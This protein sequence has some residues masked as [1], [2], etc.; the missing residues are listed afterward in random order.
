MR[1]TSEKEGGGGITNDGS[2]Q[3]YGWEEESTNPQ[4]QACT[5]NLIAQDELSSEVSH[6]NIMGLTFSNSVGPVC[7]AFTATKDSQ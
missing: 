1:E 3:C 7:K 4:E 6:R 2:H 5:K